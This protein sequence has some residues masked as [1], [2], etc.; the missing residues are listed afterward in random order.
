VSD[1]FREVDEEVRRDQLKKLWERY[2]GYVIALAFLFVV[3][4]AGWRG[5]QWWQAKQAAEAGAAFTAAL[6][7]GELGK[8]EEAGT[9]FAKIAKE[10]TASYRALAALREA[11]ELAQRD[12]NAAVAAYDALANNGSLGPVLQDE[13]ALRAGY[14]LVDTASYDEMR[15]R[16]EPLTGLDRTFR[17]S[18]RALLAFSAW[19]ANDVT[20][21]RRWLVTI[22]GDI[23]T[24]ATTRSQAEML[25]TMIGADGKS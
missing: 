10:G 16:I 7:L 12:P 6:M 8:H 23:E 1:I 18:A 5:Y 24:P 15:R 17:H 4:V 2:G 19:R 14:I 11:T 20:A 25:M 9:A 13:A 22:L 21:A 3:G